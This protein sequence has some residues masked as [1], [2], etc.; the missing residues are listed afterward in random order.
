MA[1]AMAKEGQREHRLP[2]QSGALWVSAGLLGLLVAASAL[3]PILAPHDPLHIVMSR[4]QLPPAWQS[5]GEPSF[6][7]GTDGLGRDVL[8]RLLFG[9]RISLLVGLTSVIIAGLIGTILGVIAGFGSPLIDAAIMRLA[10]IQL[11]FPAFLFALAIMAVL[12]PGLVNVIIVL[13]VT[14]WVVYARVARAQVLSLREVPFIEA[15]RAQGASASRIALKH[16][17]PNMLGPLVVVAT[18]AVSGAMISEAVL[19]F[20]GLG[21]GPST[22]SWGAMLSDGTHYVFTAWW[23]VTFPGL[24]ISFAVLSVNLLGDWLRD[25]LDPTLRV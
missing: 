11:A 24:A 23:L 3:A 1:A 14:N 21:V 10:D 8:S 25:R 6:P 2:R 12:G 18:F 16:L 15:A 20:L 5:G 13:G 17:L 22:P 7:L 19:S 9:G 4:V